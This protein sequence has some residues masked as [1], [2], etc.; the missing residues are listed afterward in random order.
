MVLASQYQFKLLVDCRS[1]ARLGTFAM[2]MT[3]LND[4]ICTAVMITRM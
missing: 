3:S 1:R 4:I 2:A